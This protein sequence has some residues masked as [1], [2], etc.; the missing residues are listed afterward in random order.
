MPFGPSGCS[1]SQHPT[2]RYIRF[3]L[4]RNFCVSASYARSASM[5]RS[6]HAP[7]ATHLCFP[8]F[9]SGSEAEGRASNACPSSLATIPSPAMRTGTFPSARFLSARSWRRLSARFIVV[10]SGSAVLVA[11]PGLAVDDIAGLE[12]LTADETG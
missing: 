8:C 3:S 7:V 9:L 12:T 1:Q 2:D 10:L 6:T 11:Q 5:S 4:S